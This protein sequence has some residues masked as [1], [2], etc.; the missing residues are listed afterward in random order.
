MKQLYGV[1]WF[2][3]CWDWIICDVHYDQ[4]NKIVVRNTEHVL[5][6]YRANSITLKS[7]A[8]TTTYILIT[9]YI[10]R[11]LPILCSK[12]PNAE[13]QITSLQSDASAILVPTS[14]LFAITEAQ[15]APIGECSDADFFPVSLDS[16]P[17]WILLW[18]RWW[19]WVCPSLI[20]LR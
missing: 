10:V 5:K 14:T 4:S 8:H 13:H 20:A 2:S 1:P 6:W 18:V 19:W 16:I 17:H 3:L 15:K 9:S 7:L 11:L 12:N